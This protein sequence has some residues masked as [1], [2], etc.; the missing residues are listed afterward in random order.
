[1]NDTSPYRKIAI[2]TFVQFGSKICSVLLSL[3]TVGLLTRYLGAEQY[4]WFALVFTY[5]SFFT[6]LS[7]IGFN[8][9]IVRELSRNNQQSKGALATLFNIKLIL[10]TISILLL[11]FG[12]IFL[13]YPAALK[14]A[15][16]IGAVGV[17]VGNV[18]SYGTSILQSQLK[19]DLIA[20]LDIFTK[21]VTVAVIGLCVVTKQC[22]YLIVSTVFIGNLFG[23][24]AT[25]F[26]VRDQLVFRLYINKDIVLKILKISVPVGITAFISLLYFKV[27]T[28]ILS[29]TRASTEVGIYALSYKVLENIVMLWALYVAN[30]F[31]LMSKFHGSKQ[32]TSYRDLFT[33]TLMLLTGMSIVIIA[34][35]NIFAYP[36]V[37][38]LGGTGFISSISPFKILLF[39]TPFLFLNH[40]FFNVILSFGKTKYLI[41]PLAFSL[42]LNVMMNLYAIPRFGYMGA[43]YTTVL[44]EVIIS[45]IYLYIFY[46][47]FKNELSYL[48]IMV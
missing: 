42:F 10:I 9:T 28:L 18:S 4:G 5:I 19:L 41:Q 39:A 11:A 16:L 22:F 37:R 26:L 3:L 34:C 8:Q 38:I 15:I 14:N 17:A 21:L 48:K 36:T 27:D 29:V 1:M 31:P 46:S 35:G 7:D 24:I 40:T 12:L 20:Y 47:K 30:V 6:A 33:K 45:F 25:Y 23:L 2:N 43:S 13:P 44:T 32:V